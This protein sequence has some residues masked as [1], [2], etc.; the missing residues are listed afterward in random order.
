MARVT[1]SA[2]SSGSWP[3]QTRAALTLFAALTRAS[4]AGADSSALGGRPTCTGRLGGAAAAGRRR[5]FFFA[6][7]LLA[8]SG[9][10]DGARAIGADADVGFAWSGR[11]CVNTV[12]CPH[13]RERGR[14]RFQSR[15][16]RF[17]GAFFSV[18]PADR[19]SN[20]KIMQM[21]AYNLLGLRTAS[22][23]VTGG[24]DRRQNFSRL[25]GAPPIRICQPT[26]ETHASCP[27]AIP[28][29]PGTPAKLTVTCATDRSVLCATVLV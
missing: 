3:E 9:A 21:F 29:L 4:E 5:H 6:E 1:F 23:F 26:E 12:R 20:G 11:R 25:L 18:L 27:L 14:R 7:L 28:P 13:A 22:S 8:A 15:G 2:T 19:R 17:S 10:D 16:C 24:L